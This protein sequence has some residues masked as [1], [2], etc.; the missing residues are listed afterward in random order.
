MKNWEW[1]LIIV[2]LLVIT[3]TIV[4]MVWLPQ[5]IGFIGSGL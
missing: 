3:F 4:T 1:W 5:L 2:T